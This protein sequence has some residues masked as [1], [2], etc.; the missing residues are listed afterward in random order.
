MTL[1]RQMIVWIAGPALLICLLILGLA[2][3]AQ[4]EQSKREVEQAMTRLAA[5]YAARLDGYLREAARIADTTARFLASDLDIS[6]DAVYVLLENNVRQMPLV[7]GSCLAFEP[8]TRRPVD[9][10]FAPYVYRQGDSLQRMNIDQGVYDWFGDPAYTWYT[11]P[12]KLG[13]G[14]WSEPYFDEGA[15]GIL[16]STYSAPFQAG[17]EF[18][19]VC[20][21]DI[22]LPRLRETVG[23]EL[24][25]QLDFVILGTD[26]RYVFHPDASRIMARTMFDYL[27]E[28]GRGDLASSAR[29]MIASQ[30]G[31]GAVWLDGWETDESIGAFYAPIPSTGWTFV[32]RV[33]KASVLADV[34][35]R[36]LQNAAALVGTL[37]LVCGAIY[38][39]AGKIA[40]PITQL[41][42]G[43]MEVSRG[44]LD[45]KIDESAPTTE[46]HNLA[47][48]FNR[49][50]A[51][52]RGHVERLA[53]EETERKRLE[54]DLDIARQIQQGL[55]P[56]Q[57]PDLPGYDI[58]G[59]SR[60]ANKTGGDYY[61]WQTLSDGRLLVSLAD[62]SGHG[63]GPAL[64][65]AVC[66]AYARASVAADDEELSPI[67][68]RLNA[69]LTTDM[70][71][72]RFVTFVGILLDPARH[73][74][75]MISAGHGPL[76]R[77]VRVGAELIESDADGLPLGLLP[78]NEY[79]PANEFLL[80][81]GDSVLLVT[82]GLFEWTNAAGDAYGLDRL[83]S[84]IHKFTSSSSDD[85]IQG[86]FAETQ[87][88]VGEVPQADDVTIV[89]VRRT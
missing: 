19:G 26:G 88:F 79:G 77:C 55:L 22:D 65:A 8:G 43:V 52:L 58:S 48:S 74:A 46:I 78:E 5:S 84:A 31:A 63:I 14:V 76:F 33:P 40:A 42:R 60:S 36:T 23:R 59:W 83:R 45:A 13:R 29:P 71:E 51:D 89:V 3:I 44:D 53:V 57:R 64:M 10:L 86:L 4:Y 70:P 39:V 27:A 47:A 67:I 34:W 25:E 50:T 73:R 15:G 61:D 18:G 41:E 7:Y 68:D 72:G 37:L 38:F 21:I 85:M 9:E 11:Q 66:R 24:D 49:M 1:R 30:A 82:D 69:L 2:A 32:C 35:R 20:T 17:N 12:K 87:K 16:M 28:S 54:F 80:D 56:T 6:D 62:V 75:Q 81:P